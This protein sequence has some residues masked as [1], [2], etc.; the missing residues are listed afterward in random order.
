VKLK[1]IRRQELAVVGY[2]PL[3]GSKA[4]IVGGL[5]LAVCD[6][7][8]KLRY[9]GKVGSG[10]DDAQR[11]RFA[12]LLESERIDAPPI[13]LDEKIKD[14]R[15]S[16]PKLVAEV[17]FMEWS[18]D[19]KLRH[20][21]FVGLRDDKAPFDC[22]RE[23]ERP[24]PPPPPSRVKLTNPD[25]VL[26]PRDG[27]RKRDVLELYEALAPAMLPHLAGRPLTLQRWPDGI[28]EEAWY[29]HRRGL[30]AEHL[31]TY[32]LEGKEQIVCDD[33][34]GLR[35]LANLAAL[36]MHSWS[37]HIGKGARTQEELE[38]D[39]LY[40]DYAIIDLDP[41]SGPWSHAIDVALAARL[42]LDRLELPSFVKTT[43]KRGLH[44]CVPFA[45]GPSH[46]E[47][48]RLAEHIATAIARVLPELA[49]IERSIPKR[50]GRLYIDY[51]P[52]GRG[53]TIAAPYTLRA[54]DGAPVSTP[55]RWSEVGPAL[56]PKAFN[57]RT[58]RR[59]LDAHGDLF[60]GVLRGGPDIRPLLA[61]LG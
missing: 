58:I 2:T 1:C 21:T 37:A 9:A 48:T 15:W 11:K 30:G 23:D 14:A 43:G 56:D 7:Q 3:T 13:L 6:E 25:K 20:P 32:K 49:T 16:T 33:V 31:R 54:L 59:R 41:G 5:I 34:D 17:S 51:L 52:N 12:E 45:R 35:Q 18:D 10:L 28:D 24:A 47:A 61:R 29:Q 53:K 38:R 44:I 50:Q 26:F 60:A 46:A 57:L 55:I 22:T 4:K 19:G 42:L 39:L 27:I 8:G 40:P 36:T